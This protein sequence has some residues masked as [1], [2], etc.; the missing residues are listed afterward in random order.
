[1]NTT[2]T[3]NTAARQAGLRAVAALGSRAK[4]RATFLSSEGITPSKGVK[5]ATDALNNYDTHHDALTAKANNRDAILTAYTKGNADTALNDAAQ[6]RAAL[7]V[8]HEQDVRALLVSDLEDALKTQTRETLPTLIDRFNTL[9]E[10]FTTTWRTHFN[11]PLSALDM[12]GTEASNHYPHL[13][14]TG[15]HMNALADFLDL[16]YPSADKYGTRYGRNLAHAYAADVTNGRTHQIDSLG[17]N[18]PETAWLDDPEAKPIA[19][20]LTILQTAARPGTT[21]S[22]RLDR[23]AEATDVALLERMYADWQ[24]NKSAYPRLALYAPVWW[25]QQ[26]TS[27]TRRH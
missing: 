12:L 4:T 18:R 8:L 14:E 1:M 20:W 10:D 23:D 27:R 11:A 6:A 2:T 16:D 9:A 26:A 25:E 15:T 13:L 3:T 21:T 7:D 5:A 24:D 19:R 17:G 22:I